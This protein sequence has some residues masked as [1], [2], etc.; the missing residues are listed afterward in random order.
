[1]LL[2]TFFKH[3]DKTCGMKGARHGWGL[4][5]IH[6]QRTWVP[7]GQTT[8]DSRAL[9]HNLDNNQPEQ[10]ELSQWPPFSYLLSLPPPTPENQRKPNTSPKLITYDAHFTSSFLMSSISKQ[11]ILEVSPFFHYKVFQLSCLLNPSEGGWLPFYNEL[12]INSLGLHLGSL[13]LFLKNQPWFEP[14]HEPRAF[15]VCD[16]FCVSQCGGV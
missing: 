16:F 3:Q 13:C 9:T 11:N 7:N 15:H 5:I 2:E 10:A 14:V 1:M 6:K 4:L 12:W 8:Y